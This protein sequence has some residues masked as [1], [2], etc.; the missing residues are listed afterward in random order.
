M[1]VVLQFC[2]FVCRGGGGSIFDWSCLTVFVAHQLE[3]VDL[4]ELGKDELPSHVRHFHLKLLDLQVPQFHR[5]F[6]VVL[7]VLACN[8]P[9]VVFLDNSHEFLGAEALQALGVAEAGHHFLWYT[10][11]L[12][13]CERGEGGRLIPWGRSMVREESGR[14]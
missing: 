8:P 12:G 9:V 5:V 10:H 7:F 6:Q 1:C 14:D 11:V 3:G 4:F 2:F 13:L